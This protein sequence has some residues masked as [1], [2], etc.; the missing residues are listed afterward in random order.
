[1]RST[2]TL[3]TD[4]APGWGGKLVMSS[5]HTG[6]PGRWTLPR[7]WSR[8]TR[9]GPSKAQNMTTIRPSCWRWA[10]VSMPLPTMSR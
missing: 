7:P 6:S 8:T 5:S 2:D 4:R 9:G 1:M 3:I 10:T